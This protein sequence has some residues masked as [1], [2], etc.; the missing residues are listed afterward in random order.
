MLGKV[1]ELLGLGREA[2]YRKE[3]AANVPANTAQEKILGARLLYFGKEKELYEKIAE[4]LGL[5]KIRNAKF[6]KNGYEDYNVLIQAGK[7]KYFVKIFSFLRSEKDVKR[8]IEIINAAAEAGVSSPKIIEFN[9]KQLQ[10]ITLGGK[11]LRFIVMEWIEGKTLYETRSGVTGKQIEF[12]AKQAALINKIPL[13]P[14]VLYDSWA[15]TNFEKEYGQAKKYLGQKEKALIEPVLA[16]Y[17]KINYSLLPKC[18]VHGDL[19][20]T[21]IIKDRKGKLWI[22][23]FMVANYCPRVQEIAVLASN[24]LNAPND[25]KA[26]R[27]LEIFLNEYQ[28]HAYLSFK[29]RDCLSVVISAAHAMHIIGAAKAKHEHNIDTVENKYWHEQGLKGLLNWSGKK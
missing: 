17:K 21:N 20:K 25:R 13:K 6:M 29:E 15:I 24:L 1:I 2:Q 23:D 22:V 4:H 8:G 5:G 26:A 12:I 3:L 18:F 16:E 14:A 11:E 7:S 10:K 19:L 9:S 27:N 28:K